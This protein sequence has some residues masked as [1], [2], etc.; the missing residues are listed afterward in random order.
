[1]VNPD[2]NGSGDNG[3][4]QQ[5]V[6]VELQVT[7]RDDGTLAAGVLNATSG[8]ASGAELVRLGASADANISATTA[9][10]ANRT[11]FVERPFQLA[12][13]VY[14][15]ATIRAT[16]REYSAQRPGQRINM[17]AQ[18]ELYFIRVEPPVANERPTVETVELVVDGNVGLTSVSENDADLTGDSL[19][20][21]FNVRDGDFASPRNQSLSA[22]VAIQIDGTGV[23]FEEGTSATI[24]G[25]DGG[26]AT[27]TYSGLRHNPHS[28]GTTAFTLA[29]TEQE[30]R[31]FSD[32]IYQYPSRAEGEVSPAF[33][34]TSANDAL[35]SCADNQSA[36]PFCSQE[37]TPATFELANDFEDFT[38]TRDVRIYLQ[39]D[40]LTFP[41]SSGPND[42]PR[43][44]T[45]LSSVSFTSG[46]LNATFLR[47][48]ISVGTPKAE[49]SDA[50]NLGGIVV[51]VPV[52]VTVTQAQFNRLN[53]EPENTEI[54]FGLMFADGNATAADASAVPV[55]GNIRFEA[56]RIANEPAVLSALTIGGVSFSNNSVTTIET[57]QFE[58]ALGA[59]AANILSF[60]VM[61]P[62]GDGGDDDAASGQS[63]EVT[64]E[65]TAAPD[66]S[67]Q[68]S[69]SSGEGGSTQLIRLGVDL[70]NS[71]AK[72]TGEIPS[73][74]L[75]QPFSAQPFRLARNVWGEAVIRATVIE[76]LEVGE[77]T[78]MI[79]TRSES[80]HINVAQPADNAEPTVDS[81]EW[82]VGE[83]VVLSSVS[84][85]DA[86]LTGTS[87]TFRFNVSD[88]DFVS[89]RNQVLSDVAIQIDGTSAVFE[90]RYSG[91]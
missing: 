26:A 85:N 73:G 49:A 72:I 10:G 29:L 84:E 66:G 78:R 32:T 31:G 51:T 42:L 12:R 55:T 27:V 63:V 7:S 35:I 89:P 30:P 62:D 38:Q 8:R 52:T 17:G 60:T 33:E 61:N 46:R 59:L 48:I 28:F 11:M 40:D 37:N 69:P 57:N 36:R 18:P 14:G 82:V 76:T 2:G 1:M 65:V 53:V 50:A 71:N 24:T 23:V 34:V 21:R 77:L 75:D 67:S 22:D 64:L 68:F 39:D 70:F 47:E 43:V 87:L 45:N 91:Y 81:V 74:A 3:V 9:A 83:R 13:N 90:D 15:D 86:A 56:G 19:T 6:E 25:A 79:G 16:I 54:S 20:F 41:G 80:Y 88:A 58:D 5:I 4:R 44:T